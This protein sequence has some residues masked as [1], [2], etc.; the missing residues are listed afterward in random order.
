MQQSTPDRSSSAGTRSREARRVVVSSFL[1]TTI[2]Y[3]DYLLY[4]T[5][6]ALVFGPVFFPDLS[7]AAATIASL[8]SFAVG[9][10]A[11]PL[12]GIV[13]GHFGDRLGRKKMLVVSMTLMGLG[14]V[15]IG[16]IPPASMIGSWAAIILVTL[17]VC[18]GVAIGG[19]WG[20]AALMALEHAEPRRRGF[21]ASFTNAGAPMGGVLGTL[22]MM[23]AAQLP[24]DQFLSW[25]W[26]VPFL[27]S[28]VMLAVGLF[29]RLSITESPIFRAAVEQDRREKDEALPIIEVLK[30][31]KTVLVAAG[32]CVTSFALQSII[33]TF[34]IGYA[35]QHGTSRTDALLGV[36]AGSFVAVFLVLGYANLSDRI[37]RRPVMV[38]GA[39]GIILL[40][41][42]MFSVLGSGAPTSVF[43]AFLLFSVCQNAMFGPMAGFLTEQ[44]A[45]RSRYTGASV[46]FQLAAL[47]GGF[48]PTVLAALAGGAHGGIWPM[49]LFVMA[50]A[51]VS[52]VLI[53]ITNETRDRDLVA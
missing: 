19:E 4:G 31:P 51:A 41:Y 24:D 16:L 32:A 8:A 10:V 46:S 42:P 49:S 33:T 52:A 7:A 18:Q 53:L 15:L 3:Y 26:R 29:V 23:V 39:L 22:A 12:G 11:R 48:A 6:A 34:G 28:A 35:V 36:A 30:A 43:L 50:L 40:A 1:G 37:G 47:G 38:G 44:F 45:T 25:G 20:G 21:Y 9:Y 5:A 13:F 17:R 27:L 2:E 14:S